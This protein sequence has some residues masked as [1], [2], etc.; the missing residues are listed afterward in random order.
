MTIPVARS[1]EGWP[2]DIRHMHVQCMS[3]HNFGWYQLH[4]CNISIASQEGIEATI[5]T[6]IVNK[7]WLFPFRKLGVRISWV[8]VYLLSTL[9]SACQH[10]ES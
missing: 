4:G 1:I 6:I 5:D 10:A 9:S 3:K 2:I 7:C 8:A